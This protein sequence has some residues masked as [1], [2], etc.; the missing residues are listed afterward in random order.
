MSFVPLAQSNDQ[1]SVVETTRKAL[2]PTYKTI[3]SLS[4]GTVP[5]EEGK[6]RLVHSHAL[7]QEDLG[8]FIVDILQ[9]T[10]W[11]QNEL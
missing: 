11:R 9:G 4:C 1:I 3:L 5:I 7:E 6:D 8:P 10:T 2:K